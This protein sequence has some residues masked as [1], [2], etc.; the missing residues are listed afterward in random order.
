MSPPSR[1]CSRSHRSRD[2]SHYKSSRCSG[3]ANDIITESISM[4]NNGKR[5]RGEYFQSTSASAKVN[6]K[7]R[8]VDGAILQVLNYRPQ[9]PHPFHL[10]EPQFPVEHLQQASSVMSSPIFTINDQQEIHE[11]AHGTSDLFMSSAHR[12]Q[13]QNILPLQP[14]LLQLQL[15][16]NHQPAKSVGFDGPRSVASSNQS[17]DNSSCCERDQSAEVEDGYDGASERGRGENDC[18]DEASDNDL[19]MTIDVVR[20][21]APAIPAGISDAPK[22]VK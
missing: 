21:D 17:M 2:G 12:L 8:N 13:C 15:Q 19:D 9:P 6:Y 5:K 1:R 18:L 22:A 7:H 10:K 11:Q 3:D 14:P 16:H 20:S 4:S